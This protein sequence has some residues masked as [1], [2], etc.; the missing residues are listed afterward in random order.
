VPSQDAVLGGQ[1]LILQQQL[2]TDISLPVE[3]G[4]DLSISRDQ[5]LD[6]LTANLMVMLL[7]KCSANPLDR[8]VIFLAEHGEETDP[9]DVG[10]RFQGRTPQSRSP[11]WK[12]H[13]GAC[14][15]SQTVLPFRDRPEIVR[16]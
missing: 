15:W 14:A 3:T 5:A 12:K 9:T 13:P 4:K 8:D 1:V 7:L 10:T 16:P 11:L 6:V 2:L